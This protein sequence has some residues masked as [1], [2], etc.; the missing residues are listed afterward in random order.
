M[1]RARQMPV[2]WAWEIQEINGRRRKPETNPLRPGEERQL[3]LLTAMR[4]D[5]MDKAWDRWPGWYGVPGGD[6]G[7]LASEITKAIKAGYLRRWRSTTPKRWV[8]ETR[9]DGTAGARGWRSSSAGGCGHTRLDITP[10][11]H[12]RIAILD[13]R[14]KRK[15]RHDPS[16]RRHGWGGRLRQHEID[17]HERRRQAAMERPR[18]YLAGRAEG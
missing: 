7:S 5:R 6:N 1:P 11:G 17:R 3:F 18:A 13:A 8:P 2:T 4:D 16:G 15:T 9:F 12:A 14:V 10:S